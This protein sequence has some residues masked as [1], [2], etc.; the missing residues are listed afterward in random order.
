MKK[1]ILL[2][3]LFSFAQNFSQNTIENIRV[4]SNLTVC[5][6]FDTVT[7]R[8][9]SSS[10]L[11]KPIISSTLPSNYMYAGIVNNPNIISVNSSVVT[12]PIIQ[13]DTLEPG[14]ADSVSFLVKVICSATTDRITVNLLDS[15]SSVLNSLNSLNINVYTPIISIT[16]L[17]NTTSGNQSGINLTALLIGDQYVRTFRISYDAS[18]G[19]LDTVVVEVPIDHHNLIGV[20]DGLINFSLGGDTAFYAFTI[21]DFGGFPLSPTNNQ[22]TFTDTVEV[23]TC[24]IG[25]VLSNTV[26]ARWGCLN[27]LCNSEDESTTAAMAPGNPN[28]TTAMAGRGYIRANGTTQNNR[29]SM[30]GNTNFV[31]VTISNTATGGAENAAYNVSPMFWITNSF[32]SSQMSLLNTH[33]FD[34]IT[35]NG[36][37]IP[38]HTNNSYGSPQFDSLTALNYSGLGLSDADGDGF[39]DDLMPDSSI[40]VVIYWTGDYN[41]KTNCGNISFHFQSYRGLNISFDDNCGIPKTPIIRTGYNIQASGSFG[42]S[43]NVI[44]ADPLATDSTPF[45]IVFEESFAHTFDAN[46]FR[47]RKQFIVPKGVKAIDTSYNWRHDLDTIITYPG[48]THDTIEFWSINLRNGLS[49]L[50]NADFINICDSNID[51]CGVLKIKLK[52]WVY[53]TNDT[54]LVCQ[55]HT[56]HCD[57]IEVI[58]SCPGDRKGLNVKNTSLTRA[59]FGWTDSTMTT[60]INPNTDTGL[61]LDKAHFY[62]SL[63]VTSTISIKDTAT[64]ELLIEILMGNTLSNYIPNSTTIEIYDVSLG[65]SFPFTLDFQ[66]TETTISG[67]D[68]YLFDISKYFDSVRYLSGN[69]GYL[70]GGQTSSSV[71]RQDSVVITSHYYSDQ[72]SGFIGYNL[73]TNVTAYLNDSSTECAPIDA[74]SIRL[75][76]NDV[77]LFGNFRRGSACNYSYCGAGRHEAYQEDHT[78]NHF[79]WEYKPTTIIDSLVVTWDPTYLS[80][81]KDSGALND[82]HPVFD[83]SFYKIFDDELRFYYNKIPFEYGNG[84]QGAKWTTFWFKTNCANTSSSYRPFVRA[85]GRRYLLGYGNVK[86]ASWSGSTQGSNG[87]LDVPDV[88]LSV[89][90]PIQQAISDTVCWDVRLTNTDVANYIENNWLDFQKGS[91]SINIFEVIDVTDTLAPD[92]LSLINYFGGNKWIKLDSIQAGATRTYRVCG[93]FTGCYNDSIEIRSS[94]NC[95]A[96]PVDPVTGYNPNDYVCNSNV[97]SSFLNLK[98]RLAILENPIIAQSAMPQDYCDTINYSVRIRNGGA[99]KVKNVKFRTRL[100]PSNVVVVPGSSVMEWPYNSGSFISLPD[101]VISGTDYVWDLSTNFISGILPDILLA[102]SNSATISFS[103]TTGCPFV[104][105]DQLTFITEG[106]QMCGAIDYS[107][108]QSS[109]PVIFNGTPSTSGTYFTGTLSIDT[110]NVCKDY[111]F[112]SIKAIADSGIATGSNNYIRLQFPDTNIIIVGSIFNVTNSGYLQSSTP[113]SIVYNGYR[114]YEWNLTPGMPIGDSVSFDL[115]LGLA[116]F[117]I[118]CGQIESE[119]LTTEKYTLPCSIDASVC[120]DIS[121][122]SSRDTATIDIQKSVL[123]YYGGEASLNGC[124]DTMDVSFNFTNTGVDIDQNQLVFKIYFDTNKNGLAEYQEPYITYNYIDSLNAGDSASISFG[125]G[126]LNLNNLAYSCALIVTLDSSASC[127]CD[128]QTQQIP[129]DLYY[130]FPDTIVTCNRSANLTSCIPSGNFPNRRYRWSGSNITYL[131]STNTLNPSFYQTSNPSSIQYRT[132]YLESRNPG[133]AAFI[134]TVTVK[135]FPDVEK[136]TLYVAVPRNGSAVSECADTSQL[137]GAF[138]SISSC[139]GFNTTYNGEIISFNNNCASITPSNISTFTTDTACII[140]C[141]GSCCDTTIFIYLLQPN[142]D[143]VRIQINPFLDTNITHCVSDSEIYTTPVILDNFVGYDV[144]GFSWPFTNPG[145]CPTWLYNFSNQFTSPCPT[146]INNP[147]DLAAAMT[148]VDVNGNTWVAN[149]TNIVLAGNNGNPADYYYIYSFSPSFSISYPTNVPGTKILTT[150]DSSDLSYLGDTIFIDSLC[151]NLFIDTSFT[152]DTAC[153]VICDLYGICDTTIIIYGV[154]DTIPPYLSCKDTTLYLGYSTITIDTSYILDSVYDPYL[155]QVWIS[156]D[157][158]NCS[159]TGVNPVTIYA[160]DINNNVDS[161]IAFVTIIDTINPII[162]CLNTAISLNSSGVYRIDTSLIF[163]GASDNCGIDSIWVKSTDT[164][165]NCNTGSSTTATLYVLDVNGNLDS[166]IST[167]TITDNLT[168]TA[169]CKDTII[170]LD[171]TG[172]YII[173]SSYI[174]N[175]SSDNCSYTAQLSQSNFNCNHLGNNQVKLLVTD[176]SNNKDSCYANVLVIDTLSPTVICNNITVQLNSVGQATITTSDIDGGTNDNCGIVAMTISKSTFYCS[177]I[178]VNN[179]TL[180]ARDASGNIDSCIAQVTIIDNLSPVI[181]CPADSSDTIVGIC[182]Y[183]IPDLTSLLTS[184]DNCDTNAL[185]VTQSPSPGTVIDITNGNNNMVTTSITI[186]ATDL[187]SNSDVCSFN[188]TVT[189]IDELEITQFFSPN[190]DGQ[191]DTWLIPHITEYPDNKVSVFNRYGNL[192]YEQTNYQNDW[193]GTINID[194]GVNMV[195]G[196]VNKSV[197]P[198]GTYFYIVNLGEG[199]PTYTGYVQIMK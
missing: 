119:L 162:S 135:V 53:A 63:K 152:G 71:Y 186:T 27:L 139:N 2:I 99:G 90:T 32:G 151:T 199:F 198:S 39:I 48:T 170:Y 76:K 22:F 103:I 177:N 185:I 163:G 19:E 17:Q 81:E 161:C 148:A 10:G 70:F 176:P 130:D 105:G 77:W 106:E 153:I 49:D 5:N 174:D 128:Y 1:L 133:C 59:T 132:Y 8:V 183:T 178:G 30:C 158:F 140:T 167:I 124:L 52:S 145:S 189:C 156:K 79:S 47:M 184:T 16:G 175:G 87:S 187:S 12:N 149:G 82:T 73:N 195:V 123:A 107:I 192:V 191:N 92:T 116:S 83:S 172:A 45:N 6:D 37:N 125:I 67:V 57:S 194:K 157:T 197:I 118:A 155:T 115:N 122:V 3:C 66:P 144:S 86:Q 35:V 165:V 136:D 179:V 15:N 18:F 120:N 74:S 80:L 146:G 40:T 69:S 108:P 109:N 150:C 14:V 75:L 64:D 60:K 96:Y 72:I 89:I 23:A 160:R 78:V 126:S 193:N 171:N 101:P 41:T 61:V 25:G 4:P 50:F 98:G 188:V 180:K 29:F 129:I 26:T 100:T 142:R 117:D 36:V 93:I 7:I 51:N 159:D 68:Y 20:S 110:F 111:A 24:G 121:V 54:G 134:D 168:P 137:N 31:R 21:A 94:Y 58:K 182:E 102:D 181:T 164:L 141:S 38:Y 169:I 88:N 113:T 13:I 11:K 154:I 104:I 28:I 34:S 91:S 62:D 65:I 143:T 9:S 56:V 114:V 95:S 84:T 138:T 112:T 131:S 127:D 33:S 46:T 173:D 196:E 42:N 147:S 55:V 190:G 43:I 97:K 166:C 85:Y 44:S